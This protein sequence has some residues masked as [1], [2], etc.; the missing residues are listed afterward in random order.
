MKFT[1]MEERDQNQL[2]ILFL[3]IFIFSFAL[4]LLEFNKQ[5]SYTSYQKIQFENAGTTL[6]ANLYFPAKDL[7]FQQKQPLVIYVHGLAS[8]RNFDIRFPIELT[9]RGFFVASID[10]H[11]HGES[12]GTIFDINLNTGRLA[13]VDDVAV[14]LDFLE[15]LPVFQER[16]NSSQIGLVGHSLGGMISLLNNVYDSRINATVVLNPL[17]NYGVIVH[18]TF[19]NNMP[20]DILNETNTQNLL[21]IAHV[22]DT[23]LDYK[24]HALIAHQLTKAPLIN[25]SKPVSGS[26][27]LLMNNEVDVITINWL[28][29]VFFNSDTKNG[30]IVIS[31]LF[32]YLFLGTNLLILI[33]IM[34]LLISL[35]SNL[36][37][38]T[39]KIESE[40]I[41][42]K[43]FDSPKL[44]KI[45]Q[46]LILIGSVVIFLFVWITFSRVFQLL[47]I[48]YAS[49][50]LLGIYALAYLGSHLYKL[51]QKNEKFSFSYIMSAAKGRLKSQLHI[52]CMMYGFLA[53]GIFQALYVALSVSYPFAFVWPTNTRSIIFGFTA[54]PIFLAVEIFYRKI[55]YPRLRFIKRESLR[56]KAQIILAIIVQF[57]I[58]LNT[59]LWTALPALT[60]SYL[61]ILVVI[62]INTLIYEKTK[63]AIVRIIFSLDVIFFFFGAAISTALGIDI[64]IYLFI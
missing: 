61:I 55:V 26:P 44:K 39:P 34:F 20:V 25:F 6:Y 14:L 29:N 30:P 38:L 1:D 5:Q 46:I 21:L 28:E 62:I 35:S 43:E 42:L 32:N 16:I 4:V 40:E 33:F 50:T 60:V 13:I 31:Y 41:I 7:E 63:R 11:G 53:S 57:M 10:Y 51:H 48:Y 59:T 8:D 58:F 18:P 37:S 19:E 22:N 56:T 45:H 23:T 52:G 17:V 36:F 2:F 12:G 47:G 49:F 27:H 24:Q 64:A 15:K 9:K 3:A 54:L